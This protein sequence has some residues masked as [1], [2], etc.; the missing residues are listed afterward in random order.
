MNDSLSSFF[1]SSRGLRDGDPL[2]HFLFV[3]LIKALSRMRSATIN[4]GR[5]SGF[6][7]GFR[8]SSVFDISHLLFADETLVFCGAKSE[9]LCFLCALFLSFEVV[10]DLKINL[11]KSDLILLGNVENVDGWWAFWVEVFSLPLKYNGL[12]LV[13]S[14]KAKYIW[15]VALE[16]IECRLTIWKRMYLF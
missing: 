11:S 9:H 5:L 6:S 14:Y 1:S 13:A 3:V 16:K 7:V 2:S 8:H 10:Y 15:V 12:L 4:R